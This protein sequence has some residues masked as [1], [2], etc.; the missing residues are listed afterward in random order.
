MRRSALRAEAL[1]T[2]VLGTWSTTTWSR[3]LPTSG[4]LSVAGA[5]VYRTALLMA[6]V[7]VAAQSVLHYGTVVLLGG[8]IDRLNAGL[9][10]SV[11]SWTGTVALWTAS[12]GALSLA[13]LTA[14]R[15]RSLLLLAAGIAFLSLDD[16]VS[17][18]ERVGGLL[19][20]IGPLE[21]TSR[22]TWPVLYAPLMLGLATLL[23]RCAGALP[24]LLGAAVH[25]ALVG[26]GAAIVLEFV[27]PL[28]GA[29]GSW[30]GDAFYELEV[31]LEEG[32][33]LLSWTV[34]AGCLLAG[35]V[36]LLESTI[37]RDH[38]GEVPSVG[39]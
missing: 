30:K 25:L 14:R 39:R 5:R 4:E 33:E 36:T 11:W 23:W 24:R 32:L 22:M 21:E 27:S 26:L 17:I 18:H 12:L 13:A 19:T 31:V 35:A 15:R 8:R 29:A 3:A 2:R 1:V 6:A 34:I 20:A 16:A 28:I 38:P 7:A 9:E 37:A 10:M